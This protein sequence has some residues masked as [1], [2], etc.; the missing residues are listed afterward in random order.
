MRNIIQIFI[1]GIIICDFCF[2]KTIYVD[3][4]APGNN[5]SN[6]NQACN[7][8]QSAFALNVPNGVSLD[9]SGLDHRRG[10]AGDARVHDLLQ[11]RL[12]GQ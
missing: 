7:E 9:Q 1:Y 10:L 3:I 6:W 11:Q 5:G 2:G 4:D 8:I 12:R